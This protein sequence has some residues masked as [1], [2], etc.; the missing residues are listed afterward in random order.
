M[1]RVLSLG[2]D[3]VKTG[4]SNANKATKVSQLRYP[5]AIWRF[6]L[7]INCCL[8]SSSGSVISPIAQRSGNR[9]SLLDQSLEP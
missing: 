6:F 4:S 7:V 5:K 1:E 9:S 2:Q 8:F 3:S